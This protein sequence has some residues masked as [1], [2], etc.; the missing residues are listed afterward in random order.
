MARSNIL[1]Q[2]NWTCLVKIPEY[3]VLSEPIDG[4]TYRLEED[5]EYYSKRYDKYITLKKGKLSDGATGAM[6]IHSLG[7]WVHDKLCDD[8]VFDD[9]TE[10]TNLQASTIL[11]DILS[12]EGRWARSKYWWLTTWILGG[13]KARQNGMW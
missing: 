13:G 12:S 5:A 9:G 8:G 6:D 3:T 4:K 2:Q 1:V 10:C 7:W 11:A